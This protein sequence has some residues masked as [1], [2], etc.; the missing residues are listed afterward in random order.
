[1]KPAR[2]FPTTA[3]IIVRVTGEKDGEVY[4]TLSD[5]LEAHASNHCARLGTVC[6]SESDQS[7]AVAQRDQEAAL[8]QD[9]AGD[10][11]VERKK[12]VYAA[13]APA[14]LAMRKDVGDLVCQ[15]DALLEPQIGY[16]EKVYKDKLQIRVHHPGGVALF[17]TAAAPYDEMIWKNFNEVVVCKTR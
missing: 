8:R 5:G 7:N 12:R 9:A 17:G 6:F 13:E 15:P 14:R 2:I 16:V 10:V 4:V 3:D 11:E 1:V